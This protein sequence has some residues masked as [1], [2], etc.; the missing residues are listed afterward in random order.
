MQQC[1]LSIEQLSASAVVIP[2]VNLNRQLPLCAS[3]SS[4]LK[5]FADP[6]HAGAPVAIVLVHVNMAVLANCFQCMR[7]YASSDL[8]KVYFESLECLVCMW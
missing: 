4:R 2:I 1:S 3:S 8:L 5:R 6:V 7:R